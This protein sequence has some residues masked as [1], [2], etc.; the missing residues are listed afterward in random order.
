ME[1]SGECSGVVV[2]KSE[3]D[4]V[5]AWCPE[6]GKM[7]VSPTAG[8]K[9]MKLC[10][11]F[12]FT[13]KQLDKNPD[14]WIAISATPIAPLA[15]TKFLKTLSNIN[16]TVVT[17]VLIGA[18]HSTSAI[19]YAE[20]FGRVDL[21]VLRLAVPGSSP[22]ALKAGATF[23]ATLI[24]M[25]PKN[26]CEWG[27]RRL[28]QLLTDTVCDFGVRQ[29]VAHFDRFDGKEGLCWLRSVDGLLISFGHCDYYSEEGGS[30]KPGDRFTAWVGQRRPVALHVRAFY[31]E[32][33]TDQP[34]LPSPLSSIPSSPTTSAA[35]FSYSDDASSQLNGL[36]LNVRMEDKESQTDASKTNGALVDDG[37]SIIDRIIKNRTIY[38]AICASDSS[39]L[40]DL[41][42]VF[43]P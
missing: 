2:M 3:D 12:A 17:T 9:N 14:R 29:V 22:N 39:I 10:D 16:V 5:I 18:V 26:D 34:A 19:G 20:F 27:V 40:R 24:K 13:I 30:F 28:E 36:S 31:V 25:K 35:V 21:T 1:F 33:L 4:T 11:W 41:Y 6:V 42:S 23:L 8:A 37:R 7:K 32:R 43:N 38:D 15:P